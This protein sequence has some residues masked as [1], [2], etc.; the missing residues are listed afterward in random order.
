LSVLADD[1]GEAWKRFD[2]IADSENEDVRL[3]VA[4]AGADKENVERGLAEVEALYCT[5]PAAGGGVRLAMRPRIAAL[6]RFVP[7]DSVSPQV[8]LREAGHG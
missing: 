5:G 3:R 2:G 1:A 4:F 6:S 8:Q 7:R